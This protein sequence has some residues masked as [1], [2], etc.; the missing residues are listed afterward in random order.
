MPSKTK[1]QASSSHHRPGLLEDM[2]TV[3][4]SCHG[5]TVGTIAQASPRQPTYFQY[6]PS[7]INHG[8]AISPFSLP[9]SSQVFRADP[10]RF[11]NLIPIFDDSLPDDWGRLLVERRL[12]AAGIESRFLS[13]LARLAL[14]GKDGMG[15]LEYSPAVQLPAQVEGIDYDL[16]ASRCQELINDKNPEG[17]DELYAFGSSSGGARPKVMVDIDREPWIVKFPA[18]GD[19]STSGAEEERLSHLAAA[20]GIR[21][22]QTM[23]IP[24]NLGDGYFASKRFDRR[25]SASGTSEKVHM[26]SAAALLEASPFDEGLDY[27]DLM[28]LTLRL[29][30]SIADCEQ[31]FL[32]MCFNVEVGNCDDHFRNFSYLYDEM[33]AEWHLSPAYDITRSPG[34]LG[35]HATLVNGRGAG[36][37]DADL[38]AAA[39][40][41]GL[42]ERRARALL[43]RVRDTVR[44]NME[45]QPN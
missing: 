5:R 9:L 14:V 22:P 28:K 13:P 26:A 12:A 17:L 42:K 45:S 29:T 36:I 30:G 8:F 15:A 40:C 44:R 20:C 43:E 2:T 33:R 11:S 37:R 1:K 27:C 21:V 34:F 10:S 35:E 4:V 31:L 32:V 23:L 16:L 19:A 39:S 25:Q 24:S 7:W 41:G 38:L 6:A 3:T 18:P